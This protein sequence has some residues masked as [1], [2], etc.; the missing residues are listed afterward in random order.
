MQ[1]RFT[2]PMFVSRTSAAVV[3]PRFRA[4]TLGGTLRT[5]VYVVVVVDAPLLVYAAERAMKVGNAALGFQME[6]HRTLAARE[7]GFRGI[8]S[9]VLV[10]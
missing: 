7:V 1:S 8:R 3:Q 6:P 4:Y 10:V 2:C 9:A 5:Q